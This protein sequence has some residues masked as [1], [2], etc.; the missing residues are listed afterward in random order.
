MRQHGFEP[1]EDYEHLVKEGRGRRVFP[2]APEQ[3]LLLKKPLG[4]TPHG[5]GTRLELDSYAYRTIYRWIQQGMPYGRSDDPKI[6]SIEVLPKHAS[7]VLNGT[8]ARPA[9]RRSPQYRARCT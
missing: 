7:E 6:T 5:G 1:T 2:A 8:A 3:S 4:E 9:R